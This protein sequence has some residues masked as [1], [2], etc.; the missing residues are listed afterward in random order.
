MS[1]ELMKFTYLD[2]AVILII[3]VFAVTNAKKG[4]GGALLRF[5]PTLLGFLLSWKVSGNVIKYVRTT[6]VFSIL[7]KKIEGGL[8]I[9]SLLPDM[10]A[11]AQNEIISGMNLPDFIKNALVSNNNSVVYS[12][13]NAQTL[14]EY[15]AGFIAN[16]FISIAVVILLYFAGL[17]IGRLILKAL[18]IVNDVPV[19]GWFSKL[20]G[21]AVGIIKGIC[22]VWIIGIAVTFLC[23]KPW[24]Q[25]FMAMLEKSFAAGWLYRN[26]I[27]LYV[28][29]SIIA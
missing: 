15:V 13:F 20:G 2:A 6:P 1:P 22:I 17:L 29:L 9:E 26:N 10:T 11:S 18:D 8:N 12:I 5:M 19:L 3:A 23:T 28:V 4:I 21:F 27:L 16:I 7:M 25:D 14:K 24:A